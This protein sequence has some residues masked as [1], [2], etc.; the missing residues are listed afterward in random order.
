MKETL[1]TERVGGPVTSRTC[2]SVQKKVQS[3]QK[4]ESTWLFLPPGPRGH[5]ASSS[6]TPPGQRRWR[7][8]LGQ[9]VFSD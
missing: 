1:I 9:V 8:R 6:G 7:G 5:P 4:F 3:E 2:P